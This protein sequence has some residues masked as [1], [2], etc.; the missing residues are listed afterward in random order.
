MSGV[1]H[2]LENKLINKINDLC[3]YGNN[4]QHNMGF[5][6]N[7]QLNFFRVRLINSAN[8]SENAIFKKY[9][10]NSAHSSC[11]HMLTTLVH[12]QGV[13]VERTNTPPS[14]NKQ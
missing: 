12:H 5:K 14:E 3:V 8:Y 10:K 13:A 7:S 11:S 9:V 6:T 4:R 1:C 2:E